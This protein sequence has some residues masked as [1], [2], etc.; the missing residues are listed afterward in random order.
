MIKQFAIGIVVL[1]GS[2]TVSFAGEVAKKVNVGTYVNVP[3][4]TGAKLG[5]VISDTARP[6]PPGPGGSDALQ[7]RPGIDSNINTRVRPKP[8]GPGG[9]EAL[10][11]INSINQTR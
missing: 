11:Q 8:K 1:L 6:K 4:S 3:I 7:A 9:T 5:D 2:A 10:P